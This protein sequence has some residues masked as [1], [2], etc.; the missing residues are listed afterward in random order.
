MLIYAVYDERSNKSGPIH[1]SAGNIGTK[2]TMNITSPQLPS[3]THPL[4]LQ[5]IG[6]SMSSS[7]GT[8]TID[9][10]NN[11]QFLEALPRA[12]GGS[13][14]TWKAWEPQEPTGNV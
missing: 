1:D 5:L 9:I 11:Q 8:T 7:N 10:G 2:V 13:N 6:C 4:T 3:S 14:S 12:L